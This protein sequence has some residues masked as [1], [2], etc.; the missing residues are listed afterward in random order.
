MEKKSLKARLSPQHDYSIYDIEKP[1]FR[2]Y[3]LKD[4]TDTTFKSDYHKIKI[5]ET[6]RIFRTLND[7]TVAEYFRYQPFVIDRLRSSSLT[8]IDNERDVSD[9]TIS[10]V[11]SFIGVKVDKEQAFEIAAFLCSALM[12]PIKDSKYTHPL[13]KNLFIHNQE[14]VK[15]LTDGTRGD[16]EPERKR[17]LYKS[18][19]DYLR[20][21]DPRSNRRDLSRLFSDEDKSWSCFFN[22]IVIPSIFVKDL[23]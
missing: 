15:V 22:N 16:Y 4:Y 9:L 21:R 14:M 11:M 6:I 5:N 23:C 7:L 3:P 20:E 19:N 17:D 8:D 2:K 13:F 10:E 18:I 1:E 12:E